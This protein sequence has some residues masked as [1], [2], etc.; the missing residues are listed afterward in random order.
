MRW[1]P[2]GKTVDVDPARKGGRVLGA[3][4]SQRITNRLPWLDAIA[5]KVQPKV[6]EAVDR[7]GTPL[8]NAL[9]GRWF[10]VPLHPV[11]TDVP[12]GSW[13]ATMALD[14]VDF[15]TGSKTA[16]NAADGALAVGLAGGFAAAAVGLSDW[17][18]LSGGSR[19]MGV[20][21]GLFNAA[22]LALNL[23]SLGARAAGKRNAGRLL[24]LAGYS[25]NGMGAHLGGEL[26]YGYGLRVN[27]NVFEAPGPDEFTPVLQ[28]GELPEGGV[29]RVEVEGVGVLL[30]RAS[31]G[32][33][34][35]I[36]AT[37]NHFSGPLEDGE[38]E[39]DTVVCPWHKSRFDLCTGEVLDGPAVFP[40]A[41][42]ET[43]LRD[44][45]I[46]VKAHPENVQNLV[47]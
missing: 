34:C 27:R 13:T 19:K 32:R 38:R 15:L 23:A 20:A 47:R 11:L 18:Y 36:A 8:R 37:C 9:D 7:G 14:A 33:I 6:Q 43:R 46:E 42:Y 3:T 30:S 22:G 41:V 2:V 1:P 21:H 35:A 5:E 10:G 25:L 29:R 45:S 39:G 16:R 40:Q 12:V 44:G 17:R 24:F 28:E 4:F 26:S 31:D